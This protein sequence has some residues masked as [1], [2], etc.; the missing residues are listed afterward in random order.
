MSQYFPPYKSSGGNIK[1]EVDLSNYATKTDLK[2]ITHV[3]I[4]NFVSKTSLASLK[5]K[6][7]E[8]DIDKL[9]PVPNGLANLSN[10]VKDDVV[11]K[12]ECNK[13]VTKI[14]NTDTTGFVLK[15]KF[16]TDK[17]DLEKKINDV[18]KEFLIQMVQSKYRF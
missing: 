11:K 7:D 13:L 16:D 8:L 2:N 3:D 12:T 4:S 9:T 1:V 14:D 17:S 10:V 18:D 6:V 15:T 5:T